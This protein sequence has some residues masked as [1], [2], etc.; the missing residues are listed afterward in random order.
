MAE[1]RNYLGLHELIEK[2]K[3]AD[4]DIILIQD[5]ENTKRIS[6]RD[7]RDSLITDD[8]LPSTHRIYSSIKLNDAIEGFDKRL[9]Y[10]LGGVNGEIEQIKENYA[11]LK[12]VDNKI[13]DFSKY[14]IY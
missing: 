14:I 3:L 13:S 6:F 7:F 10:G 8:E 11:S 1:E 4:D 9:T 2:T 12:D 5:E